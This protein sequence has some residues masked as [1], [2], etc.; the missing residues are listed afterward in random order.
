MTSVVVRVSTIYVPCMTTVIC[1]V[2]AR[3][4]VVE[5]VAMRIVSEDAE[6]PVAVAPIEWA[7]EIV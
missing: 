1:V 2:D 3:T 7:V 5:V 4:T 6:V